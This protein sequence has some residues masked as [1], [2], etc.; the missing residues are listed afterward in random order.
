MRQGSTQDRPAAAVSGVPD[1]AAAP[2]RSA[3]NQRHQT[4]RPRLQTSRTSGPVRSVPRAPVARPIPVSTGCAVYVPLPPS[5]PEDLPIGNRRRRRASGR[6]C[7]PTEP[8]GPA[9]PYTDFSSAGRPAGQSAVRGAS[10]GCAPLDRAI[11]VRTSA[12]QRPNAGG[13]AS[14]PPPRTVARDV[15]GRSVPPIVTRTTSALRSKEQSNAKCN[16]RIRT[17]AG[18]P[19]WDSRARG[20]QE[21]G[22]PRITATGSWTSTRH[23][24]TRRRRITIRPPISTPTSRSRSLIGPTRVRPTEDTAPP[25]IEAPNAPDLNQTFS[26]FSPLGENKAGEVVFGTVPSSRISAQASTRRTT[27]RT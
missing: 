5:R 9:V 21:Q 1:P 6:D 4:R 12:S 26:N 10:R 22:Q 16:S 20:P 17:S 18:D 7:A 3:T 15:P 27:M 2:R 19:R 8:T 24:F 13:Q 23:H 14:R 11:A 25:S